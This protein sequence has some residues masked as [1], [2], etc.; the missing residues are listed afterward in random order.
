VN[1][2]AFVERREED[3]MRL[4]RLCD[5]ADSGASKLTGQDMREYVRLYRRV[6]T[7]LSVARTK[8]R[9]LALVDFLNDLVGRAYGT[10]YR[11][12]R[13]SVWRALADGAA[14]SAQAFRRRIWFIVASAAL[15]FGSAVFAYNVLNLFPASRDV[16]LPPGYEKLFDVWKSGHFE[17]RSGTEAAFMTGFYANNNP[18]VAVLTG[19]V[20]AGTFGVFSIYLLYANGEMLGTLAHEVAPAG[21]LGFLISSIAPHGIQELSG[22]ILSGSAGLL[23]GW[24]LISPGGRTRGKALQAVGRDAIVLLTTS[25]IL[26]FMAAPIEGFFSFNPRIPAEGKVAF[27]TVCVIFWAY[28]WSS[29]GRSKPEA[30]VS[31]PPSP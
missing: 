11:T 4:T 20:G 25:V 15:F 8:T 6:S 30:M 1:E 2:Q 23:L 17:E 16:L 9:N 26:M 3:W 12:P 22:C 31:R 27:A 19:A 24:A 10:L 18:R 28:F 5:V 7:D 21:K 14:L 29:F 13:T